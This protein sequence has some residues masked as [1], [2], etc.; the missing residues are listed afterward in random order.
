MPFLWTFGLA[1]TIIEFLKAVKFQIVLCIID[2][3][4]ALHILELQS[5]VVF[6]DLI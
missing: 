1:Y 3:N 4:Q 5:V 6:Q 2:I